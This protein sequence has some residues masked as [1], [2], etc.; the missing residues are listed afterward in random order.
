MASYTVPGMSDADA[1]KVRVTL[2]HRLTALTDLHLT[3]KHIHWNVVGPNFISVHEMLDP[4]IDAIRLM[5]DDVAERLPTLGGD[6]LATPGAIV[7]GRTWD[8]YSVNRATTDAH[9]GALD[10]V[11][12]GVIADHRKAIA[13]FDDLDLVSQD[14]MIGQSDKLEMYHWFV[15][16][17]LE[18]KSGNLSTT[19][20]TGEQDAA[21]KA[22]DAA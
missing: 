4:H 19:G 7:A 17:H 20:A 18:D 3:L 16:A 9:L 10:Q 13:E 11:Y 21:K 12:A 14:M 5:S 1:E 15:R 22:A 8:D 2:Q 6:P